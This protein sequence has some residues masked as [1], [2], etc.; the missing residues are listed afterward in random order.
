MAVQK[1]TEKKIA[2]LVRAGRG[3]GVGAN[4]QPW[5]QAMDFSSLGVTRRVRSSKTGREHHLFSNAEFDFFLCAEWSNEV[6][7]IREQFPLDRTLTQSIADKIG[8]RH[9]FYPGTHVPT[10]MTA[11]FFLIVMRD[12]EAK[13]LAVNIKP[14]DAFPDDRV[15]DKLELQRRYFDAIGVEH[16]LVLASNIPKQVAANIHTIRNAQLREHELG[17]ESNKFEGY[18]SG[19]LNWVSSLSLEQHKFT[20]PHLLRSFESL[21]ALEPGT[22]MKTFYLLVADRTIEINL[23]CLDVSVEPWHEL[24]LAIHAPT[25]QRAA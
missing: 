3:E 22:G 17:N 13:E 7:D 24:V 25:S 23:Q 2:Q 19:L 16:A 5:I 11:D 1:W 21:F 9:P 6:V 10:V 4:Y 8:C 18:K 14:D 20:T 15:L 12:G